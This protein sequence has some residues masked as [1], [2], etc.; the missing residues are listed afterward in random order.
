MQHPFST[1]RFVASTLGMELKDVEVKTV[2]MGGGF[3]GKDDT[4]ALVCA[5]AALCAHLL[6]RPVKLTYSREMSMRE[7]Y[8]RHPYILQ[9]RM[10]IKKDGR[11]IFVKVRMVADSGAYCS[12]IWSIHQ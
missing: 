2:P 6:G 12:V 8:K 1:R 9:Y 7:S 10:G 4:A 5:R 3:G 11:I